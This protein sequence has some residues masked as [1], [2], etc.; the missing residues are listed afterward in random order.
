MARANID[1][2]QTALENR[3]EID[4]V[5]IDGDTSEVIFRALLDSFDEDLEDE[6][7]DEL[8]L[9]VANITHLGDFFGVEVEL[10]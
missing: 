3:D 10:A 8:G 5:E 6:I 9:E 2:T 1:K 7:E 4:E